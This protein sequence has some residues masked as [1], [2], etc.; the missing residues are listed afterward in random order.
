MAA[1][2]IRQGGEEW[3]VPQQM[4]DFCHMRDIFVNDWVDKEIGQNVALPSP[5]VPIVQSMAIGQYIVC[6]LSRGY[7]IYGCAS[8]LAEKP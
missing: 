7:E 6:F 1:R 4:C 2:S 8:E 5:G 3:T